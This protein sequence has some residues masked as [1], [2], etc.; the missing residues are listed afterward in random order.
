MT[1]EAMKA[2]L[3][4]AA[5]EAATRRLRAITQSKA[6]KQLKADD[7][8]H[9]VDDPPPLNVFLS[10][11]KRDGIAIAKQLRDGVR[12]F[13]QLTAWYDSNDLPYG[14]SWKSPMETAA[15]EG[16][17]ALIATVTDAYPTRPWCRQEVKLARTPRPVNNKSLIWTVQPVVAV[18][19]PRF[20]WVRSL[21]MLAGVP[22]IGWTGQS[23]GENTA[24]VV[25]RL[26]L[27]ML[28]VQ[29]H[30]YVAQALYGALG[31]PKDT[32]FI[33]WVPDPWTLIALREKLK[34][35]AIEVNC[36]VYPGYGL[37]TVE[38]A[39]L[40]PALQTIGSDV[41]LKNY[42]EVWP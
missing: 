35:E 2:A 27:E 1:D 36:I 29:T 15:K 34:D 38:I 6:V 10:H 31:E 16:T 41:A 23:S 18:H 30:R 8:S 14:A 42:E 28:L 13:G 5:T 3:R 12:E 9:L 32:C 24:K 37:N 17:A 25:D 19:Q 39:E 7:R 20:N 26:V 40:Q 11:A 21:P 4:R 33:T 22:R